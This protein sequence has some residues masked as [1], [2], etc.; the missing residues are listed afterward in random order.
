[1]ARSA[2]L[3]VRVV[4]V[5]GAGASDARRRVA[6]LLLRA[7]NAS[8]PPVSPAVPEGSPLARSDADPTSDGAHMTD[9]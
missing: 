5:R 3:V 1:V 8:L 7:A 9:P 6:D 2:G 4:P